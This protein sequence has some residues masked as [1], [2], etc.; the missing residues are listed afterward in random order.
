[1]YRIK[2]TAEEWEQ[3]CRDTGYYH[4]RW[5]TRE[6]VDAFARG[7]RIK[8]LVMNTDSSLDF[9][10][11]DFSQIDYRFQGFSEQDFL[12]STGYFRIGGGV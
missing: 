10:Q 6:F 9:N 12:N 11:T 8:D 5:L 1:M 7:G 2:L 4:N 3:I